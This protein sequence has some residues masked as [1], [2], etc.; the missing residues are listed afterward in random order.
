VKTSTTS[1]LFA[2][3]GV[4][5]LGTAPQQRLRGR[6]LTKADVLFYQRGTCRIAVK[7]YSPRPFLVRSI[8]GRLLISREVFAFRAVGELPGLPCFLGRLGPYA[9]ATEWLDALPLKGLAPAE[10]TPQI[11]PRLRTIVADLHARGVALGDL[12]HRDVLIGPQ[13]QVHI[14]DLATA[15]VLGSQPGPIRRFLFH[16]LS[17]QDRVAVARMEARYT[18][19]DMEAAVAS[20]GPRAAAWHGRGRT[21]KLW[22]NRLRR[23]V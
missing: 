16:R 11:W 23:R 2:A 22:L 19:G 13:G 8:V 3:D 7:D 17:D 5:L 12:H 14:V 9:L 15:V 18:G 20:I 21:A 1:D 4:E 6:N 10:I